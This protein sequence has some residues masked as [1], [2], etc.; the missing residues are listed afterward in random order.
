[1]HGPAMRRLAM[2]PLKIEDKQLVV[3]GVFDGPLGPP[4]S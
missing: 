4:V 2:V 1:V 3:A